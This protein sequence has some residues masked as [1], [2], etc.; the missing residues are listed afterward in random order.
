MKQF[1]NEFM[2]FVKKY[3]VLGLAIG[4]V[5][6][7]AVTGLVTAIVV[8]LVNPLIGLLLPTKSLAEYTWT[9]HG[10]VFQIG[11]VLLALINFVIVAALIFLVIQKLLK[12]DEAK[13]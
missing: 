10:S 2:E 8:G 11:T 5:I 1:V 9:F 13:K 4:L 3:Q 12:V 6:G 7:T